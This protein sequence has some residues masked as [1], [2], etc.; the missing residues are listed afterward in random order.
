MSNSPVRSANAIAEAAAHFCQVLVIG[1]GG[2]RS[3]PRCSRGLQPA[4]GLHHVAF[5][6]TRTRAE[7]R[8]YT[9]ATGPNFSGTCQ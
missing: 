7:A 3:I 5:R 8:D 1:D 9:R 4:F 2:L 6:P